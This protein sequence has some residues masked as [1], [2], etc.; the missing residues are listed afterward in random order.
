MHQILDHGVAVLNNETE[1]DWYIAF[2]GGHHFHKLHAAFDSTNFPYTEGKNIEIIDWGCGQALATCVLIDYLIKN[3]IKPNV[4]LI[5]LIEPSSIALQRGCNFIHQM[6]Q[7]DISV[8]PIIRTINKYIGDLTTSDLASEPDTIKIHLFSNII[9]VETINLNK[10]Y[11]L[12]I[13]S[14]KGLNRIICTSPNNNRQHRLHNFYNLF[15]QSC[16]VNNSISSNEEILG[17]IFYFKNQRYETLKIGRCE[18]Q[19]TVNLT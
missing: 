12:M 6:F 18:K 3:C 1:C 15:S 8:I 14:F 16:Q 5:T 7:N 9:D 19:F 13:N 11:K 4:V 17:E 2:Y 10:L